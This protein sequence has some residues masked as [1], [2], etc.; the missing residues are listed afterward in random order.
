MH[1]VSVLICRDDNSLVCVGESVTMSK[2]DPMMVKTIDVLDK[3]GI[4]EKMSLIMQIDALQHMKVTFA[5][6]Q[7]FN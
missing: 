5:G 4:H 1:L 6:G 7:K 3:F 2:I